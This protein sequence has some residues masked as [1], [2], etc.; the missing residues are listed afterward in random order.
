VKSYGATGKPFSPR[1]TLPKIERQVADAGPVV[2]HSICGNLVSVLL[3]SYN[4][5]ILVGDAAGPTAL[6]REYSPFCSVEAG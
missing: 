5:S 3:L 2:S 4:G 1:T 6:R